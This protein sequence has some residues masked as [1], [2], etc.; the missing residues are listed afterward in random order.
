MAENGA[1]RVLTIN[2]GSSSLK[3]SLYQMGPTETRVLAGSLERIGLRGGVWHIRDADGQTLVDEGREFPDHDAALK[4]LLD[5]LEQRF[6][7]RHVDAVGHRVVHGGPTYSEPHL[8]TAELLETLEEIVRLAPEHLPH[9]LKAI[10]TIRRLLSRDEAGR[11][12]RHRL[13]P[14]HARGR[15]AHPHAAKPLERRRVAIRFSRAF[16]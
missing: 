12:L 11:L 9:E 6:P 8:V 14:P 7:G 4:T 10:D 16:V 15:P 1:I 13:P 2:S 3:W 5:W